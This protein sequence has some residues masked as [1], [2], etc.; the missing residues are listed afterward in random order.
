[1]PCDGYYCRP[2]VAVSLALSP[3]WV[4]FY[5]NDQFGVD[6]FSSPAGFILV[7]ANI[8][9]ATLILRYAPDGEGPMDFVA[10]VPMTL[11][12]FAIA[13]T[14]LDSIAD[15]L[16]ELLEL[17]GILLRIPNTLMGLTILAFGNSIQDLVA[18]VSLSKK[19]LNTM[20]LTAW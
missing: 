7:A 1:V 12:A 11:Y 19:G 8:T 13:A 10:V 9:V 4:Y 2:I 3:I 16:V 17:F 20:A 15:K 14:W 18:N 5:F 6:I